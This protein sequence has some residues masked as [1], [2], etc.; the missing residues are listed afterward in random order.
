MSISHSAEAFI[1]EASGGAMVNNIIVISGD[2]E[3][4]SLWLE[5]NKS[6]IE[7]AGSS[8]DIARTDAPLSDRALRVFQAALP[9]PL[10]RPITRKS[11]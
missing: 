1:P 3:P 2:E 9:S 8:E 10:C 4:S 11:R 6:S 7:K 5:T